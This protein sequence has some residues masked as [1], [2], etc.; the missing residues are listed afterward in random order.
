MTSMSNYR[1][2]KDYE[3]IVQEILSKPISKI[4]TLMPHV[5]IN[6]MKKGIQNLIDFLKRNGSV[7]GENRFGIKLLDQPGGAELEDQLSVSAITDAISEGNNLITVNS[8]GY[9]VY[10]NSFIE[11][12]N[13]SIGDASEGDVIALVDS[14]RYL[15]LYA[16]GRC[17]KEIDVLNPMSNPRQPTKFSRLAKDFPLI[18]LDHYEKHVKYAQSTG[19]WD[20]RS[21]RILRCT[22]QNTEFIFHKDL[23]V[24][25]DDHRT[26]F[27]VFGEVRKLSPD[28]TDIELVTIKGAKRYILEVKWLGKNA[29]NTEYKEDRIEAGIKQIKQYLQRERQT[30]IAALVIYNGRSETE[31]QG[32]ATSAASFNEDWCELLGWGNE[33]V[34]ERGKCLVLLLDS[35][36]ASTA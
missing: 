20:D 23:W 16:S 5:N 3:N 15:E 22:P 35:K 12:S 2:P 19:H 14:G 32:L 26:D 30:L 28:R 24:W 1:L 25:L 18:I 4:V 8:D 10:P 34:P 6:E 7:I 21:K 36:T 29:N 9:I 17:I 27:V 31:Y 33:E 11:L 13:E